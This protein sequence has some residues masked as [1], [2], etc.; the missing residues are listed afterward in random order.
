MAAWQLARAAEL[1]EKRR[2]QR[3]QQKR[4]TAEG[5]CRLSISASTRR[6]EEEPQWHQ[7]EGFYETGHEASFSTLKVKIALREGLFN[8]ALVA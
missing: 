7:A 8:C 5:S 6:G 2:W 3:Q 4:W 1:L